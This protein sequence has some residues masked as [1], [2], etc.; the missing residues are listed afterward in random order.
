MV[1]SGNQPRVPPARALTGQIPEGSKPA[2][3]RS[4]LLV[5]PAP[6]VAQVLPSAMIAAK[7]LQIVP[8]TAFVQFSDRLRAEICLAKT[9]NLYIKPQIA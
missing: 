8:T 9:V 5:T 1:G 7:L 2:R 4:W 6:D 3:T